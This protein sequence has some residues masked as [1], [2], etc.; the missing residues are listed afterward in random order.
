MARKTI[1]INLDSPQAIEFWEAFKLKWEL[2]PFVFTVSFSDVPG[3][4]DFITID[5]YRNAQY[6]QYT[7]DHALKS[8]DL[9][10]FPVTAPTSVQVKKITESHAYIPR[11]EIEK[12]LR[13]TP[14]SLRTYYIT[15][16]LPPNEDNSKYKFCFTKHGGNDLYSN[17]GFSNYIFE[18]DIYAL[19]DGSVSLFG[20]KYPSIDSLLCDDNEI[21][22]HHI[23]PISGYFVKLRIG[24][25][26]THLPNSSFIQRCV[27]TLFSSSGEGVTTSDQHKRQ[28]I[29]GCK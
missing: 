20:I 23:N 17:S 29:L 16:P 25:A 18:R 14:S 28:R 6:K 21:Y 27:G 26:L 5:R 3:G 10:K 24:T 4:P 22:V 13:Q 19:P 15:D 11:S 8:Y 1:R 9:P 2:I 12:Y 7:L